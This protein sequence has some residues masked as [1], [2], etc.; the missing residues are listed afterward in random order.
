MPQTPKKSSASVLSAGDPSHTVWY[1]AAMEELVGVVKQLSHARD[2]ESVMRIVRKAARELTGA[3]GATFVL[4]DDDKCYYADEDAITPLWKGQRFPM[5]A[6]ISGWVM[7]NG[8][9]AVIEDI[10]NDPRIPA[11]A[12]R[13]TF[14]KSLAMVPIRTEAPVGAIGNYW[15]QR[16]QPRNEEVAILQ[17]LADVTSV[18][19]EN[20]QLYTELQGKVR[21]LQESNYELS[22]FAWVASHDL[23]EPLRTIVTRVELLSQRYHNQL[24]DRAQDYVHT[25]AEGAR[26]LQQ[27][28]Q[29]LLVHASAEKVENFH[30][31]ALAQVLREVRQDMHTLIVESNAEIFV[32][33]LPQVQGNPALLGQLFQNLLGN[34]I[35]FRKAGT[36]PHIHIGCREEGAEWHITVEDNGI[37]IDPAYRERVF[38]LFQRLHTQ[39]VYPGSGIGLATCRKIV[40]LHSGR[41]WVEAAPAGGSAFHILLPRAYKDHGN[42]A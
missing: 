24:D 13:P 21:A 36:K 19:I 2:L 29:D 34:A 20:A 37:G 35:K 22:R 6:C 16:H 15:A 32:D 27:L 41:I 23:Q 1:I 17:A 40:E 9:P 42:D 11:D 4:R 5:S 14:V 38:G 39:D 18:A 8:K 33:N 31:V 28:V 26:R 30:I 10:Y 3:D 25:A 12:Y 7:L